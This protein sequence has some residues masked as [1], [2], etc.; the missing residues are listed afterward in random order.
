MQLRDR[1]PVDAVGGGDFVTGN[2]T[3]EPGER[4]VD[5]DVDLDALPM[6][7]R[8]CVHERTVR[9]MADLLGLCVDGAMPARLAT[10]NDEL[11]RLRAVNRRLR[12]A[13]GAVVEVG[14]LI[15][16]N[17]PEVDEEIVG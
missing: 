5:L 4:I 8:L 7:G 12:D 16:I 1:Y 13:L 9:L 15:K 2:S 6:W 10:A 14:A 17:M 11:M 3:I